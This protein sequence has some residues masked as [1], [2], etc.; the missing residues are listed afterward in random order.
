[1]KYIIL[2][3]I[4]TNMLYSYNSKEINDFYNNYYSSKNYDINLLKA[5]NSQTY[6]NIYN[7]INSKNK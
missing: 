1:M 7:I 4:I 2:I 6:K 3:V 5:N